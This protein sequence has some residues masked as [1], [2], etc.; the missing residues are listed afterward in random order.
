M[1]FSSRPFCG[2]HW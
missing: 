1:K 2:Q